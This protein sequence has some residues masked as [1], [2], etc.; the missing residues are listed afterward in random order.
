MHTD[1]TKQPDLI[2]NELEAIAVGICDRDRRLNIQVGV[3]WLKNG[4]DLIK[5][6]ALQQHGGFEAWCLKRLKYGKRT[7]EKLM[8]AAEV[9][10]PLLK[11]VPDSDLPPPTPVY[12]LSAPSVPAD[13]REKYAPKVVAGEKVTGEI[14][15]ALKRFR[16]VKLDGGKE[17]NGSA[18]EPGIYASKNASS[19]DNSTLL[20]IKTSFMELLGNNISALFDLVEASG[21]G[22][23]FTPEFECEIRKTANQSYKS[24]K[25][26][27]NNE[28]YTA[29]DVGPMR[30]ILIRRLQPSEKI[31]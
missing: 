9:F 20:P 3:C 30:D 2:E 18:D 11:S 12:L 25:L 24:T 1:L 6:K 16:D 14:R 21:P 10:G 29:S 8:Q 7:A 28:R 31:E 5:A 13:I 27:P 17:S 23:I 26:M 22:V 15:T 19:V 4:Q